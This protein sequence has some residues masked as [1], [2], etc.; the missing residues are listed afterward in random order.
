MITDGTGQ[1]SR[2]GFDAKN[3]YSPPLGSYATLT[4]VSG[5]GYQLVDKQDTTYLFT[6][7]DGTGTWL[8]SKITTKAGLAQTFAYT[9]LGSPAVPALSSVTDA[10]SGRKLTFTWA[11]PTGAAYYHVASVTTSDAVPGQASTASLWTYNYSGDELA[12]VCPPAENASDSASSA[13]ETYTYQAGTDYPAAVLDAGPYSYWRLDE[14]SGST[15][16]ASSVLSNEG[17]DNGLYGGTNVNLGSPSYP[18]PLA[19][20]ATDAA[21]ISNAYVQLPGNLVASSSYQSV[22]LWFKAAAPGVLFSY[23]NSAVSTGATTNGNYTPSLYIG[24]DGKLNGEFSYSGGNPPMTS[25]AVVD[26]G[27]WHFVVLTS[28]GATQSLYLDGVQQG[29]PLSG[30]V[31]P[32]PGGTA[33]EYL[34]AGFWGGGWPDEPDQG[35][36]DN[37][38][39]VDYLNGQVAEAAFFT[40]PLPASQIT[41]LYNDAKQSSA[42]M[43]KDVT[44]GGQYRRAEVAYNTS[45]D[46][47]VTSVTDQ[48]R[49]RR[50]WTVGELYTATW[51]RHRDLRL[52]GARPGPRR[53]LAAR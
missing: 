24:T 29:T 20:G 12:S 46:G 39:Y 9:S 16:A 38:G 13:C 22:A 30:A 51:H 35:K 4:A 45:R 15:V 37:E 32:I 19:G 33:H 44:P 6:Q 25:S 7:A 21:R 41:Q 1:Q 40:S 47:R 49:R 36:D 14:P 10:T 23:E 52:R 27:Q 8:I 28:A 18:G 3:G 11:K 48:K 17:T 26:D 31:A 34:G 5:G 53:L 43:T 42:W 50:L 2:Y